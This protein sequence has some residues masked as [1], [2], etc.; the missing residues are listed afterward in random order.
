MAYIRRV[1]DPPAV[2][3]ALVDLHDRGLREPLPLFCKT[4]AAYAGNR[5][6]PVAGARKEWVSEWSFPREDAEREHVIA[7]GG[8]LAL[9]DLLLLP[10][11]P[12]EEWEPLE[13]SRLGQLAHRLWD[14]LLAVEELIVT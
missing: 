6:D 8:V 12:G 9:E 13:E 2:L 4:S 10:P 14:P 11:G 5:A 7:F 1:D 3:A